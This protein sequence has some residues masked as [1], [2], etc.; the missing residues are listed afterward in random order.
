MEQGGV[1]VDHHSSH[2]FPERFFDLVVVLQTDNT[3]LYD[4]LKKRGYGDKKI[5]ENVQ[6][7]IM[8]VPVEEAQSSYKNEV[9]QLLTSN[10][11]DNMEQNVERIV[12]W[13]RQFCT[14]KECVS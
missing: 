11:A 8:H 14:A 4:R 7:E 3:L 2:F 5:Q 10:D 1:I 12:E 6:C 13:C 9:V